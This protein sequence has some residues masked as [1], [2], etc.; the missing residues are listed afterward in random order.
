VTVLG[1][2]VT[3]HSPFRVGSTYARDGV[4]AAL[5]RHDPLPPD[6]LKGLMRAAATGLLGLAA[7][8]HRRG[9]GPRPS[10]TATG[11][12]PTVIG[13]PSTGRAIPR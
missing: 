5:D 8:P 12:S 11:I 9:R 10:L 13:W 6:H 4:D 7:A 2:T 1:F 3:F